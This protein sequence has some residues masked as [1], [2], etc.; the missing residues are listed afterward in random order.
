[1]SRHLTYLLLSIIYSNIFSTASL[2]LK[3]NTRRSFC[4]FFVCGGI[5]TPRSALGI[6]PRN[7][8]LC[9]SG[10]FTNIWQYKC[11]EIGDIED[12]GV[13][14]NLSADDEIA[15]D[16]LILKLNLKDEDLTQFAAQNVKSNGTFI[17]S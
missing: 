3:A 5:V 2:S 17:S 11:T 4:A 1:M 9:G 13:A 6:Q 14:K 7:E 8:A 12:E 10:F 16:S 15:L